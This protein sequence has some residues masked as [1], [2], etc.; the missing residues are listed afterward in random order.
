MRDKIPAIMQ[1]VDAI[2]E[3]VT[4]MLSCFQACQHTHS[5]RQLILAYLTQE[6]TKVLA[7]QGRRGCDLGL[8]RAVCGSSILKGPQPCMQGR[9]REM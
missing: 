6:L 9:A 7:W 3:V 4:L 2:S 5:S 1:T 8:G